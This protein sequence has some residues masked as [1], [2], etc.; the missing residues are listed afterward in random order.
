[1]D[2]GPTW[3]ALR[4]HRPSHRCGPRIFLRQGAKIG[5]L[6]KAWD[7]ATQ[8]GWTV[9]DMAKDWTTVFASERG[10]AEASQ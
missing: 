2:R 5:K 7:E 8:R 1:M 3:S 6:D 4:R 9:V 10:T